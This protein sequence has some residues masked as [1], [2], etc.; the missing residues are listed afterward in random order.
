MYVM[1]N[2]FKAWHLFI[3]PVKQIKSDLSKYGCLSVLS[4]KCVA[5]TD[6]HATLLSGGE[7]RQ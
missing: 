6:L 1:L 3:E 5:F 7:E 2:V 4:P